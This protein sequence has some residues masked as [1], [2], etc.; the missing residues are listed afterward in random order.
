M[1]ASAPKARKPRVRTNTKKKLAELT[2]I[3]QQAQPPSQT[4]AEQS[5]IDTTNEEHDMPTDDSDLDD[6]KDESSGKHYCYI[7][8]TK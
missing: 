4:V 2:S 1:Q 8:M 3:A 7:E 5:N 6:L